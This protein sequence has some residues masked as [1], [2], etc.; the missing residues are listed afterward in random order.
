METV[1]ELI[2]EEIESKLNADLGLEFIV[3]DIGDDY[4][5]INIDKEV[6]SCDDYNDVVDIVE[7]FIK[8]LKG[9]YDIKCYPIECDDNNSW[10]IE[11]NGF[12]WFLE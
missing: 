3:D 5:M 11:F 9:K 7:G 8:G 6:L 1:L 10:E 12:R 4:V 2:R